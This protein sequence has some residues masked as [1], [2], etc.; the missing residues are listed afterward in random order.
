MNDKT[1]V[2]TDPSSNFFVGISDLLKQFSPKI[3]PNYIMLN[4]NE[5]YLSIDLDSEFI[6]PF[7][8]SRD[9]LEVQDRED[10]ESLNLQVEYEDI[11]NPNQNLSEID[12]F[13]P[14]TT[15]SPPFH[16][17]YQNMGID[18]NNN[19]GETLF[20]ETDE[21]YENLLNSFDTYPSSSLANIILSDFYKNL[22][23]VYQHVEKYRLETN[24][25]DIF[26]ND[27]ANTNLTWKLEVTKNNNQP[28]ISLENNLPAHIPTEF[29]TFLKKLI[30]CSGILNLPNSV[31]LS[32][33]SKYFP[34]TCDSI[35]TNLSLFKNEIR[36]FVIEMYWSCKLLK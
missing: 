35:V 3:Q 19:D 32:V 23:M 31:F 36:V 27:Y 9:F 17:I 26:M 11:T 33:L 14:N 30:D 18:V 16:L 12:Y 2:P 21:Y 34:L 20:D 8:F 10:K 13:E 22:Q 15:L 29:K 6:I 5:P 7:A 24:P 4:N 25:Q 1:G 28:H